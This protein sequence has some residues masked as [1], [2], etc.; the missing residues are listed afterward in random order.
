MNN[1]E[2]VNETPNTGEQN[3]GHICLCC[4]KKLSTKF[5]LKRHQKICQKNPSF[6]GVSKKCSVICTFCKGKYSNN[7]SLKRHLTKCS[8]NPTTPSKKKVY[9]KRSVAELKS[10]RSCQTCGKVFERNASLLYHQIRCRKKLYGTN[11]V[12]AIINLPDNRRTYEQKTRCIFCTKTFST[13]KNCT[14]HMK[15]CCMGGV[16]GKSDSFKYRCLSCC[17]QFETLKQKDQHSL[18]CVGSGLDDADIQFDVFIGPKFRNTCFQ[19][20]VVP[21][22]PFINHLT[23]LSLWKMLLKVFP[24]IEFYQRKREQYPALK[25]TVLLVSDFLPS[26]DVGI[27]NKDAVRVK[28]TQIFVHSPTVYDCYPTTNIKDD[29]LEPMFHDLVLACDTF[30]HRGSGWRIE[31]FTRLEL[32][33][34]VANPLRVA[35]CG[36]D[37]HSLPLNLAKKHALLQVKY[38]GHKDDMCF[39]WALYAGIYHMSNPN[40]D[41]SDIN[42]DDLHNFIENNKIKV[43]LSM[44]PIWP[45]NVWYG[46]SH[47]GMRI[48]DVCEEV[49]DF[50]LNFYTVSG[51]YREGGAQNSSCQNIDYERPKTKK[52]KTSNSDGFILDEC[53]ISSDDSYEDDDDSID[54]DSY[55]V[56]EE[57]DAVA[58]NE[59]S[60]YRAVDSQMSCSTGEDCHSQ[61]SSTSTGLPPDEIGLPAQNNGK[62]TKI[63][64]LSKKFANEIQPIRVTK[65]YRKVHFDFVV[66]ENQLNEDDHTHHFI[67]IRNFDRFVK[68][69]NRTK[70]AHHHCRRCLQPV[71]I[72]TN[73]AETDPMKCERFQEHIRLCNEYK[74]QKLSLPNHRFNKS[75]KFKSVHKQQEVAFV[76]FADFET[77][78][79]PNPN[80]L[81]IDKRTGVVGEDVDGNEI[82]VTS[83][84]DLGEYPVSSNRRS[85][86]DSDDEDI[87]QDG[88]VN[89]PSPREFYRQRNH[90]SMEHGNS[91]QFTSQNAISVC[92]KIIGPS[93]MNIRFPLFT[94]IGDNAARHF[95]EYS[96]EMAKYIYSTWILPNKDLDMTAEEEEYHDNTWE[97]H[98]CNIHIHNIAPIQLDPQNDES[99][100]YHCLGCEKQ[101]LEEIPRE[102]TKVPDHSHISGKYRGPAHFRCNR[103]FRLVKEDWKLPIF[104]HNGRRFD[105]HLILRALNSTDEDITVLP[106]NVEQFISFTYGKC[107]VKDSI[108]FLMKSLDKIA[109]TLPLNDQYINS[110]LEDALHGLP[111]KD[112]LRPFIKEKGKF[113]FAELT[114]VKKLLSVKDIFP[115][116]SFDND[117]EG[118]VC[119][120]EEYKKIERIWALTGNSFK[121]Y[122]N[123]YLQKDVALLAASFQNFRRKFIGYYNLDPAHYFSL[124]GYTFDCALKFTNVCLD[125]ITD[126]KVYLNIERS[127]RGGLSFVGKRHAK[128]NNPY[129]MNY[130][131]ALEHS[132][133]L[134]FDAVNLYGYGMCEPL[135]IG[136][137]TLLDSTSNQEDFFYL[138]RVSNILSLNPH[139]SKCYFYVIDGHTPNDLHDYF[140]DFPLFPEKKEMGPDDFSDYQQ[141]MYSK[142]ELRAGERLLSTLEPKTNYVVH[143]RML[144]FG[145]R[146]GFVVD[147]VS[148]IMMCDQRPWLKSYVERNNRFRTEASARNDEFEVGVMKDMNNHF[149]GKCSEQVRNRSNVSLKVEDQETRKLIS[150]PTFKRSLILNEDLTIIESTIKNIT[151]NKPIYISAA[152]LDLAKLRMYEFY[153]DVLKN[154]Y[155]DKHLSLIYTDTDSFIVHIETADVYQ[156]MLHPTMVDHFDFSSYSENSIQYANIQ[157]FHE[158]RE[159]NKK[160]L[161]KFKNELGDL[162]MD[163]A[164]ALR[165]KS[166]SYTVQVPV[167]ATPL[168][169]TQLMKIIKIPHLPDT[170]IY[171]KIVAKGVR[172][173]IQKNHLSFSHYKY[174]L[175]TLMKGIAKRIYVRQTQIKSEHHKISTSSI[176]KIALSICDTKRFYIDAVHSLPFGHFRAVDYKTK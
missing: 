134:Y 1:E 138:R 59:P 176:R 73:S 29:I 36:D 17:E 34:N 169:G 70:G 33:I 77:K 81:S 162:I 111:N 25:I 44:F 10:T 95:I 142:K 156:D 39:K 174:L 92:A 160:V 165:P 30:E 112:Q 56:D 62:G 161:G 15:H 139:G 22:D 147:N 16:T 74:V 45:L 163:E 9:R 61:T 118:S 117:L 14:S 132:Y 168:D 42:T 89:A 35:A 65:K 104:F 75:I 106:H 68:G 18:G 78:Q 8:K 141:K 49:N 144:Q 27:R 51:S 55:E 50:S 114:S 87:I 24:I 67:Y 54:N 159:K 41:I 127:L 4:G 120:V 37:D 64:R 71:R 175:K 98:I 115:I 101:F 38:G 28:P 6:K 11:V 2:I 60:F 76:M 26:Q 110:L 86:Y 157:N 123:F 154:F 155:E 83:V 164:I 153:Y 116:T 130:N 136:H 145:I 53:E 91:Y 23:N 149:Y 137:I 119:T 7:F 46:R 103:A 93:D 13:R 58:D 85:L 143:F 72:S 171:M 105:S 88:M 19:Y 43:D 31:K 57:A 172:D 3:K 66:I 94:Y 148:A 135:P 152:V 90:T 146:H 40:A 79:V 121:N 99:E 170:H 129:M 173:Y 122:H 166:Y 82:F 126:S 108:Q 131:P 133:L 128:A 158:I 69:N 102:E 109:K 48:F 124:P 21:R 84:N 150:K 97:C 96:K 167:T 32:T 80:I 63:D 5:N 113:P 47:P 52:V 100:F 107:E 12:D 151:L 20:F 125:L 140:S